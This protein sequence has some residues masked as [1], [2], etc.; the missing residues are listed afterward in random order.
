MNRDRRGRVRIVD[1]F[2]GVGA[3]VVNRQAPASQVL[4]EG[5]LERDAGMIAG[6][7]HR[8]NRARRRQPFG[9]HVGTFADDRHAPGLQRIEGEWRDVAPSHQ[10][11][12][13]SVV[14]H[15]RV[16]LGNQLEALHQEDRYVTLACDNRSTGTTKDTKITKTRA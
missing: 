11:D 16:G 1:R 5:L 2:A 12:G 15:T 8:A 4:H 13:A 14:E 6:N 9:I 10:D 7:R 3:E